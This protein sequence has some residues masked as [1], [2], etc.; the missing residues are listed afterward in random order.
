L[1]QFP[2]AFGNRVPI[3][4]ADA[5][6]FEDPASSSLPSKKASQKSAHAFIGSSQKL[7]DDP[8]FSGH[9]TPRMLL[10]NR[11]TTHMDALF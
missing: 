9:R 4:A 2:S 11:T 8:M 1:E 10:A 7:V 3:N 5:L 6:D